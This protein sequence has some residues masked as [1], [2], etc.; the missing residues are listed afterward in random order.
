[1]FLRLGSAESQGSTKGCHGFLETKML[2]GRRVVLVDLKMY[3]WRHSTLGI[4]LLTVRRQSVA[5]SVQN[6]TDS[7]KS[8]ST[9]RH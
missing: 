4:P 6:L 8:A 2:N 5:A 7:V 1:V 9:A 3:V